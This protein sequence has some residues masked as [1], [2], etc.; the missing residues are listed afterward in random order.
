MRKILAFIGAALPALAIV[1]LTACGSSGNQPSPPAPV[2]SNLLPV[3]SSATAEA[4]NP[5]DLIRRAG[6]ETQAVRGDQGFDGSRSAHGDYYDNAQDRATLSGEQLDCTTYVSATDQQQ[7]T[8][9][10]DD[11]HAIISG[12]LWRCELTAVGSDSGGY[13]FYLSPQTVAARL[14]GTV[15]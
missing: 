2:T 12:Q 11:S 15:S 8:M 9:T 10:S 13:Q 7:D 5:V 1:C 3:T 14:G 4:S 6:F